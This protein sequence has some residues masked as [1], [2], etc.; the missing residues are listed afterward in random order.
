MDKKATAFYQD[1]RGNCAQAVIAA[2]NA[3]ADDSIAID[4]YKEHGHGKA[5]QGICG[6][7]YAA[8][9]IAG[10][11]HK[12]SIR[13]HFTEQSGGYERCEDI[14]RG[15]TLRCT[16]CVSLAARLLEQ[17]TLKEQPI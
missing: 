4:E 13:R 6:A 16:E 14:R 10:S 9:S 15:K 2:W 17:T 8:Y 7:L 5:P 1:R 12:E 11:E 3:C